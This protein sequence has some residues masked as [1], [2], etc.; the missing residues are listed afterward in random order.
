MK[1]EYKQ[2]LSVVLA[3]HNEEGNIVAFLK[4]I[5]SIADEIIVVDGEST[6]RTVEIAKENGA[7]VVI[8]PNQSNFHIN[9]QIGI[10]KASYE[11]V[12][13]MDADEIITKELGSEI[14]QVVEG[15]HRELIL[16]NYPVFSRHM[17]NIA[18]R[19]HVT[20][21]QN[22]PINGYFIARKNYFLGSYL[23]HSGVYPDGVIRLFRNGH[24][25][26]PAKNVHE[27]VVIDGGVSWLKEPMIHMSDPTFSRYMWRANR[28]TDLTAQEMERQKLGVSFQTIINYMLAKPLLTAFLLFFRYKGFLDGFPGFVWALMSGL[29][30]PIAFMKYVEKT[31]ASL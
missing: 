5:A 13:Q 10:E 11:W 30:Y 2:G 1:N 9:K 15:K 7:K 22:N 14:R 6:D 3:T 27:Q 16:S 17:N 23:M 31:K 20:F 21:T 26:L 4:A 28:Y 29:H 24:G 8:V 18:T 25:K 19:D 12:L